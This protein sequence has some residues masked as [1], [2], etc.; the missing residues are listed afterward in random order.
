MAMT[1]KGRLRDSRC[2]RIVHLLLYSSPA[3]H[4]ISQPKAKKSL[5][6]WLNKQCGWQ[7]EMPQLGNTFKPETTRM[8]ETSQGLLRFAAK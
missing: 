4:A 3:N 2:D 7:I 5:S 6:W 1:P 8:I